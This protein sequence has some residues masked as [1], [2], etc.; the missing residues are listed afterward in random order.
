MFILF[1][2]H[3]IVRFK[4]LFQAAHRRAE[5]DRRAIAIFLVHIEH[6]I[7]AGHEGCGH[8]ELGDTTHPTGL[9]G[10]DKVCRVEVVH[11]PGKR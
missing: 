11:F 4:G 2:E 5:A 6:G 3:G 1:G 10:L 7:A 8:G 9:L